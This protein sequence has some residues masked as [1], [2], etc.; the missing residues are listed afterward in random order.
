MLQLFKQGGDTLYFRLDSSSFQH[1]H[2]IPFRVLQKGRDALIIKLQS[3][4]YFKE[5]KLKS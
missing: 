5:R 4:E 3:Q 2:N 1:M